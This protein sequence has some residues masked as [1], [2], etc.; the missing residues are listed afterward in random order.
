MSDQTP[1]TPASGTPAGWYPDPQNPSQ[2]RYWDGTSWSQTAPVP[3]APPMPPVPT[4]GAA[5]ETSTKAIVGLVLSILAWVLCPIIAAIVALFIAHSS[6][7]EIKASGGSIGGAGLNTATRIISWINIVAYTLG[8]IV[9]AALIGFGVLFASTS[10]IFDIDPSINTRTGLADGQYVITSVNIRVNLTDECSYGGMARDSAGTDLKDVTVYGTGPAQC[11]D[12]VEVQAV[13]F[14]V[15][16]G[17][18]T[19]TRVE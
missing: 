14:D 19:I 11:P 5:P 9:I 18:A 3:P 16:G 17:A 15:Q 4:A 13:Y 8:G 12:L 7:K 6:D 10:G 2:Q 1:Q